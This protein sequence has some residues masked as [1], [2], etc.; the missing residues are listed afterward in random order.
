MI[1]TAESLHLQGFSLFRQGFGRVS[2]GSTS[3]TLQDLQD[4]VEVASTCCCSHCLS[5]IVPLR[6]ILWL[7]LPRSSYATKPPAF[8]VIDG[9]GA[10]QRL[11]PVADQEGGSFRLQ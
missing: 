8:H 3:T 11:F 10:T 7:I 6:Y 9:I 1:D 2:T 5:A 4:I